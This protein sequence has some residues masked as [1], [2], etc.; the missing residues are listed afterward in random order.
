MAF[1]QP[2]L[3]V[4]IYSLSWIGVVAWV[5]SIYAFSR[6]ALVKRGIIRRDLRWV[7]LIA[8][9]GAPLFWIR[10]GLVMAGYPEWLTA[11]HPSQIIGA[12]V[13]LAFFGAFAVTAFELL[14]AETGERP[15]A[16]GG[17][18]AGR[19]LL[20]FYS[21]IGAWFIRPRLVR[22]EQLG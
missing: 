21:A 17:A 5:H 4:A 7:F 22:I 18:V 16:F 9:V 19:F 13:L 2:L 1:T 6:S 20:L 3:G 12:P 15:S 11:P 14:Y 8:A 10:T